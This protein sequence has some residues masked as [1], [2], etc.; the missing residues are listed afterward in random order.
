MHGSIVAAR[1]AAR[2][3]FFSITLLLAACGGG[4]GTDGGAAASSAG[5]GGATEAM[6]DDISVQ[7]ARVKRVS[8]TKSTS[9][10][11]ADT[12]TTAPATT[13]TMTATGTSGTSSTGSTSSCAAGDWNAGQWYAAGSVVR[14]AMNG[15]YYR[16]AHD[17]PGYDPT[18]STWYWEPTSCASTTTATTA[19]AP[20]T[21]ASGSFI[22]TEAQFNE[23]FPNRSS[24]YTYAGLLQALSAY[25]AMFNTGG[26]VIRRQEAAA[27][28][29][30][31]NHE[32]G[33]LQHVREINQANWP[34]YCQSS[35]EYP[36][37]PGQQ[38]YGRG[39]IQLSW[40]YNYGAAGQALGLDLLADPDLVARDSAVAWMTAMWF[41]MTQTGAG[42]HTAHNAII[43]A[44]GFGE[45]I[46]TING[47][48]E[49][50]Q[51][52][53][54]VGNTQMRMRVDYYN[55]FT[56]LLGVSAGSNLTC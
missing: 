51:P 45:T 12:S 35:R 40:N 52:A 23:M 26:D 37:A 3:A 50:N 32:T 21:T 13:D 46:R 41:W 43:N 7:A 36:C 55:R 15:N 47:G 5:T 42:Y 6:S 10:A 29:A 9:T 39:P 34:Y 19:A 4:G 54:S 44:N 28:L 8:A 48:L 25:P 31:V 1:K 33:G 18:I 16:A 27:F 2:F 38:Y 53:G 30:N 17:N 20:T 56:Q 49:C 22:V 11:T 14:Y 24:F